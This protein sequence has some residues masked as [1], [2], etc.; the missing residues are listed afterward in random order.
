MTAPDPIDLDEFCQRWGYP[1]LGTSFDRDIT[2]LVAELRA[3]REKLASHSA[4]AVMDLQAAF[5]DAK[6]RIAELEAALAGQL[7]GSGE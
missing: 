7:A 2:R 3:A 4:L 5:L 1:C 6:A